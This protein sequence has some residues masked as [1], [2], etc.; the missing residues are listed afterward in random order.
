[1]AAITPWSFPLSMG[2]CKLVPALAVGYTVI[3]L[4]SREASLS[5]LEL[6]KI[7]DEVDIP[8]GAN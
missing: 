1:M 3:L 8:K 5:S 6:V 4:P 2:V 7:I